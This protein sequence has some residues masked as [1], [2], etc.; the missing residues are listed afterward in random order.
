MLFSQ[1]L[2]YLLCSYEGDCIITKVNNQGDY[3]LFNG[4]EWGFLS[5]QLIKNLPTMQE[6][7]V[8]SLGREDPLKKEIATHSSILAWR[9]PWTEEPGGLQS[10]GSRLSDIFHC[11]NHL[12][13]H[14]SMIELPFFWRSQIPERKMLVAQ[15]YPTLWD[16]MDCSPPG[17]FVH[18]ILQARILEWVVIPFSREPNS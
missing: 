14:K 15:S 5:V 11:K 12:E 3:W 7:W 8:W 4:L 18:R 10:M 1:N 6:T 17:S 2:S 9:I 16:P 13:S